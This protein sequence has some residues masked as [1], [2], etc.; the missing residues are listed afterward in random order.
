MGRLVE[1]KGVLDLIRA[2]A[3]VK[4]KERLM[5]LFIGSGPSGKEIIELASREKVGSTTLNLL[6]MCLQ[7][8]CP[9]T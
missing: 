5:V 6:I 4:G 1:E 8:T 9:H 3:P 7:W 2:V